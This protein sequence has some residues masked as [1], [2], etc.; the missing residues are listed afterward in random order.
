MP[1]IGTSVGKSHQSKASSPSKHTSNRS[2]L[3]KK[4][5]DVV[6]G[7][8]VEHNILE[9]KKTR[10]VMAGTEVRKSV[11]ASSIEDFETRKTVTVG[12]AKSK[13]TGGAKSFAM[14]SVDAEEPLKINEDKS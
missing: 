14:S 10:N 11:T 8:S 2:D 7:P 9:E 6:Q 12:G 3:R 4:V 5:K 13:M 1:K